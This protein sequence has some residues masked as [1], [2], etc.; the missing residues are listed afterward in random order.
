MKYAAIILAAGASRR[1]GQ[2]KAL[3][4]YRGETFL[5]NLIGVFESVCQVVIVVTGHHGAAIEGGARRRAVF[6]RN[7]DPDRGQLSSLQCGLEALP[8][9]TDA[10]FFTPVDQPGIAP[11]TLHRLIAGSSGALLT[12]PR[13]EGKNGHPA[14]CGARLIAE[15]LSLPATARTHDVVHRHLAETRYVVANDPA[16]IR[17]ANTPEEY[18]KLVGA[19]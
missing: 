6:V 3:L 18:R 9:D 14:L 10:F 4:A 8:E 1:M 11:D 19:L 2:P 17:G 5:D 12:I 15:F 7:P 16:V 13:Y